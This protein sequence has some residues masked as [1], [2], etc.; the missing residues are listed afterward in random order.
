MK[1]FISLS[2]Y[3]VINW[4]A[5]VLL[6]GSPWALGFYKLGGAALFLPLLFGWIEFIMAVFSNNKHGFIKQM[7]ME[8]HLFLDVIMGSF[9]LMSPFIFHFSDKVVW[10]Q[11]L[12][13][14]LVFIAGAFTHKSPFTD[15]FRHHL[16]EGQLQSIDSE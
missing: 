13:G 4:L 3:G 12:I 2:T 11:V 8:M 16:P 7:P 5:V 15:R 14:G 10:P 1:P 6:L 9:L